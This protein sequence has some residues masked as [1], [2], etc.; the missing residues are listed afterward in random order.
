MKNSF[1]IFLVEKTSKI[2]PG[3]ILEPL[4]FENVALK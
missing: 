2:R 3:A 4:Y 1:F